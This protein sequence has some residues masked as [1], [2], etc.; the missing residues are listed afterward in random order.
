MSDEDYAHTQLVWNTFASEKTDGAYTLGHYHDLYLLTDVLL[1]ADVMH[2]FRQLCLANYKLDSWRFHTVPGL[3]LA[4]GLRMTGAQID[5]IED[6]DIHLFIEAGMRGDVACVSKRLVE[7]SDEDDVDENG[8][9]D[10]VLD[11][12]ANNLYGWAMSQPLPTGNYRWLTDQEVSAFDLSTWSENGK[13]G[14][15]L[16]VDLECPEELHD[17]LVDYPPAPEKRSVTY[18]MLSDLQRE[19]LGAYM[20]NT[21][22]WKSIPKLIP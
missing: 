14:C 15:M 16:E 6:V 7:T 12:D 8:F 13:S 1:L 21:E 20:E 3:T 10:F 11:L 4:A 22:S 2:N 19:L 9:R 5:L 17:L 18:D